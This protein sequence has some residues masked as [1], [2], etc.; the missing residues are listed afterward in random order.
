MV[1]NPRYS[2]K[3]RPTLVVFL[4]GCT[5]NEM[6]KKD[7]IV[8]SGDKGWNCTVTQD[9]PSYIQLIDPYSHAEIGRAHV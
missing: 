2:K 9:Q 8:D 1:G 5:K 7:I 3:I 6:S 4:V